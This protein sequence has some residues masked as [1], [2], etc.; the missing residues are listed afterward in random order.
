MR[1]DAQVF[2]VAGLGPLLNHRQFA[3]IA[4]LALALIGKSQG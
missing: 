1:N 4:T 3:G 2:V